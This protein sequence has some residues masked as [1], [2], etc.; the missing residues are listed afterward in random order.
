MKRKHTKD[1]IFEGFGRE[2]EE[3]L[4]LRLRPTAEEEFELLK[5]GVS[6]NSV[7]LE[8]VLKVLEVA[9]CRYRRYLVLINWVPYPEIAEALENFLGSI[10]KHEHPLEVYIDKMRKIDRAILDIHS[11]NEETYESKKRKVGEIEV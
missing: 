2:F 8:D 4:R 3:S 6:F 7:E 9:R 10:E 11:D 1:N 5:G